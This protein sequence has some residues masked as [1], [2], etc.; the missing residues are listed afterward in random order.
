MKEGVVF[1]I[2]MNDGGTR[3]S[4]SNEHATAARRLESG[5]RS[6]TPRGPGLWWLLCDDHVVV[7][8]VGQRGTS[9][10]TRE[11]R[12]VAFRLP[13]ALGVRPSSCRRRMPKRGR[14]RTGSAAEPPPRARRGC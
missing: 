9:L 13:S 2:H 4:G 8:V 10:V 14:P 1:K 6:K 5:A 3:L 7:A 12:E 11:T